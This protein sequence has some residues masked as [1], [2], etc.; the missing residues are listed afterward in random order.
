MIRRT[1]NKFAMCNYYMQK[2]DFKKYYFYY[3]HLKII[4][5]P[6]SENKSF[7]YTSH[8]FFFQ[9][10]SNTWINNHPQEKQTKFG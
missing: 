1:P 10:L 5:L 6:Q 3:A 9:I 2:D 7:R 4:I 8:G